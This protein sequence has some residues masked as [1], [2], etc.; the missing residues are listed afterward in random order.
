[1]RQRVSSNKK[2]NVIIFLLLILTVVWLLIVILLS[3][4]IQQKHPNP[5]QTL[6]DGER[7]IKPLV[8]PSAENDSG[9]V[10]LHR[11]IVVRQEPMG[12]TETIRVYE[13]LLPDSSMVVA[14]TGDILIQPGSEVYFYTLEAQK[15]ITQVPQLLRDGSLGSHTRLYTLEAEAVMLTAEMAQTIIASGHA[16]Y[17]AAK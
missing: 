13:L 2:I 15:I 8:A 5:L 11:A 3:L 10:L 9:M 17:A 7:P 12:P 16:K 1:M 6:T 14:K 4:G